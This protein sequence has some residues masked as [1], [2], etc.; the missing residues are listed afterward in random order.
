M[1]IWGGQ[2]PGDLNMAEDTILMATVGHQLARRPIGRA[3]IRR[4]GLAVK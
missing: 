3:I 4:Y 1:I 2:D